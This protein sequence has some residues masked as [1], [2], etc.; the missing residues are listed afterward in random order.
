MR[1]EHAPRSTRSNGLLSAPILRDKLASYLEDLPPTKAKG[2]TKPL[3]PAPKS[4]KARALARLEEKASKR[5]AKLLEAVVP[6]KRIIDRS[7]ASSEFKNEVRSVTPGL[8]ARWLKINCETNRTISNRTVE[9]YTR[10]MLAGRWVLT[11][12]AIGFNVKGELIDGQHRLSA[13]VASGQTV[14]LLVAT[15]LPLEFNAPIDQG[16][17][18]RIDQI[19]G[20]PSRYVSAIRGMYFLEHGQLSKS[21]KS[22][23]GLIEE[24]AQRHG[25]AIDKI[26]ELD[27]GLKTPAAF[28]SMCAFAYP[29]NRELVCKFVTQVAQG[30]MIK[31]GDPA[32]T[33]RRWLTQDN[34]RSTTQNL[35]AS[36]NALGYALRNETVERIS[37][38]EGEERAGLAGY[39]YL[40]QKRRALKIP[41]TPSHADASFIAQA[42]KSQGKKEK[43]NGQLELTS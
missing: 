15:G 39:L 36:A 11:H 9:A 3:A 14:K 27:N 16:Y 13:V 26:M 18:R 25:E 8:A 31:R 41:N 19:L 32:H 7:M 28:I 33:F 37:G 38:G 12:Q 22:Q 1:T 30:E 40:C 23:V 10:E 35:I 42:K 34:H 6:P 2:P 43:A 4:K 5:A 20:R 17:G 21:F 24:L 29:I